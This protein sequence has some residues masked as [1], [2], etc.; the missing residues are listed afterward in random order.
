MNPQVT[1]VDTKNKAATLSDCFDATNWK[2]VYT[3]S[4]KAVALAK[5]RLRYPV[6]VHA[7][8]EGDTWLITKITAD[9][10]KGC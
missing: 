9:R 2:P 8:L 6:T 5:Q 10:T 1:S 4:G 3:T 7:T